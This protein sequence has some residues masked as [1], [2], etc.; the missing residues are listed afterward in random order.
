MISEFELMIP[1]NP[2]ID[3]IDSNLWCLQIALSIRFRDITHSI[4]VLLTST[5]RMND[6]RILDNWYQKNKDI[7]Q[8]TFF[9]F[10]L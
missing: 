8:K 9:F 1:V 3:I 5:I 6:I 10:Y 7:K 2:M 4:I